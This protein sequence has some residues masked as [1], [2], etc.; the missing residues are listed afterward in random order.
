MIDM[1]YPYATI[2][3]LVD[4]SQSGNLYPGSAVKMVDSAGGVPK[5]VGCTANSDSCLGFI[6]YDIKTQAYVAG[7]PAEISVA[8]NVMYLYAVAAIA[9]GAQVQLEVTSPGTVKTITGSSGAN[10][11]GWALDKATNPGDLIRVVIRSPSF[12]FA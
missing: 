12:T 11:V 10:I 1:R 3:V 5:V 6:N 4:V 8:G 2:S 9:R 7:S